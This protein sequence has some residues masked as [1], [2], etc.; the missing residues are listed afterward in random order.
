MDQT[1]Q[2]VETKGD[3]DEP[4]EEVIVEVQDRNRQ[5]SMD[6]LIE[7]GQNAGDSHDSSGEE[8][9]VTQTSS[10]RSFQAAEVC[11][12]ELKRLV[13]DARFAM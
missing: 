6:E 3:G 11:E 4:E 9:T 8:Q 13:I 2:D 10:E 12:F 5:T 7:L 1:H